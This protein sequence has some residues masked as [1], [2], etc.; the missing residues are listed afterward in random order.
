MKLPID[1]NCEPIAH[2]SPYKPIDFNLKWL[3]KEIPETRRYMPFTDTLI[4]LKCGY[5]INM[6]MKC[7][8]CRRFQT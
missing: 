1:P 3:P 2:N 8:S 4:C 7:N 5:D 6:I